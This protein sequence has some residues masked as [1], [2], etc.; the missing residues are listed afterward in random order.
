MKKMIAVVALVV[1]LSAPAMANELAKEVNL[2][3]IHAVNRIGVTYRLCLATKTF[4]DG[5]TEY[6]GFEGIRCGELAR[7]LKEDP[8]LEDLPMTVNG[9]AYVNRQQ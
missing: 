7:D 5:T 1:G 4:S 3:D 8:D 6:Y 2:T 9:K